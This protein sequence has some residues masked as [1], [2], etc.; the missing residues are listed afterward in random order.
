VQG[1]LRRHRERRQGVEVRNGSGLYP[2]PCAR[3]P[4]QV[5]PCLPACVPALSLSHES[6]LLCCLISWPAYVHHVLQINEAFLFVCLRA[7]A[8]PFP[9]MLAAVLLTFSVDPLDQLTLYLI[10]NVSALI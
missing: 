5:C 9:L 3:S 7:C 1:P 10:R 2:D 8:F 4:I 6:M